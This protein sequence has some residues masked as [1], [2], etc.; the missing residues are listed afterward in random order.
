MRFT[1]HDFR[2]Y[3]ADAAARER[4]ISTIAETND[5][6]L[7][8][9]AHGNSEGTTACGAKAS[10]IPHNRNVRTIWFFSCNSGKQ[11]A[12][13]IAQR[14]L[15][16]LGFA[17]EAIT[18]EQATPIEIEIAQSCMSECENPSASEMYEKLR[19]GLLESAKNLIREERVLEASMVNHTRLNLR[20][21]S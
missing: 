18:F 17:T 9:I 19:G 5:K 8:I 10:D 14:G 4:L 15:V 6:A 13:E 20:V 11:I 21:F 12:P 16:A 3:A 2:R 1:I 7:L